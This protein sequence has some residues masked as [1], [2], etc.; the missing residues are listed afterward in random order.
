[1][2]FSVSVHVLITYLCIES[3]HTCAHV[4]CVVDGVT[5]VTLTFIAALSVDALAMLT[6]DTALFRA[7]ILVCNNHRLS[8]ADT[9]AR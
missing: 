3:D 2:L 4:S 6:T 5:E 8:R 9:P 1:M 7:F